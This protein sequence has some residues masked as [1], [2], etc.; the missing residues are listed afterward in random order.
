MPEFG[1]FTGCCFLPG[2]GLRGL[3]GL[4]CLMIAQ[5]PALCG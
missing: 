5:F 4:L 3:R 1:C 2:T